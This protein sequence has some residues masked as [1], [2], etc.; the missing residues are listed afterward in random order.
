MKKEKTK[1]WLLE[2]NY[3][4]RGEKGRDRKYYVLK[5]KMGNIRFISKKVSKRKGKQK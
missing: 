3:K 4:K 2:K 1:K 5:P